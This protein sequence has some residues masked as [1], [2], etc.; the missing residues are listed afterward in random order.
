MPG[1]ISLL[2]LLKENITVVADGDTMVIKSVISVSTLVNNYP[3]HISFKTDHYFKTITM[4]LN[5]KTIEFIIIK[6]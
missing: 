3:A 6:D 4:S 5:F 1:E 2:K